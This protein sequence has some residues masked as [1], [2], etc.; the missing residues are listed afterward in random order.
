M[1]HM[2]GQR[3]L[4]LWDILARYRITLKDVC[5]RAD[6]NYNSVKNNMRRHELS[7]E[8]MTRIETAAAEI[9]DEIIK[10]KEG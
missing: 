2:I 5:G 4:N 8:R 7:E 1:A 10:E 6:L 9:R 3:V